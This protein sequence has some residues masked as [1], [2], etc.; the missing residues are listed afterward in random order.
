MVSRRSRVLL[1]L[2]VFRTNT[3]I[4]VRCTI[5]SNLLCLIKRNKIFLEK[6]DKN[7]KEHQDINVLKDN[8]DSLRRSYSQLE[9]YLNSLVV[10]N[11]RVL[12]DNKFLCVE[13][14]KS[15]KEAEIKSEKLMLF[16]M[17]FMHRVKNLYTS[18]QLTKNS[19]TD[20]MPININSDFIKQE[21]DNYFKKLQTEELND[22][23]LR[24]M[25]DRY[26]A[27]NSEQLGAFPANLISFTKSK[28]NSED[29]SK[30]NL[31]GTN[32]NQQA[33]ID[34]NN[35]EDSFDITITKS[36]K[37]RKTKLN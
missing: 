27:T 31:S 2:F 20:V 6:K 9:D 25:F 10:Q 18:Q 24:S 36:T 14:F 13:I 26:V 3:S 5:N 1:T 33:N 11:A 34:C 37:L 30:D 7:L 21:L 29:L 17:T 8:L 22:E 19:T 4:R 35:Q 28:S 32:K 23:T 16:I 12:D 15:R